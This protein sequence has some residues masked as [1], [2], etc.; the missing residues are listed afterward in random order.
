MNDHAAKIDVE[1]S[2]LTYLLSDSFTQTLEAGRRAVVSVAVVDL[3]LRLGSN[4]YGSVKIRFPHVQFDHHL[5][6]RFDAGDVIT[7]LEGIFGTKPLQ[8][9]SEH[10]YPSLKSVEKTNS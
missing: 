7:N 4:V 1:S 3:C 8:P 2:R 10:G 9:V 6:S 5:P